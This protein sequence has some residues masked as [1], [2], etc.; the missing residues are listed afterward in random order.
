MLTAKYAKANIIKLARGNKFFRQIS[1]LYR[2]NYVNF[3]YYAHCIRVATAQ[4]VEF[5]MS[6]VQIRNCMSDYIKHRSD[7]VP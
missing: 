1:S 2:D 4:K 7:K 5:F 3:R 6:N